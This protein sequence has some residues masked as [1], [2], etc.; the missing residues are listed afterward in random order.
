MSWD[1]DH[2]AV[3][4]CIRLIL[5]DEFGSRLSSLPKTNPPVPSVVINHTNGILPPTTYIS[6]TFIPTNDDDSWVIDSGLITVTVPDPDNPP[7]TVQM[8]TLYQ[9]VLVN[10]N[11][12]IRVASNPNS[13]NY[14]ND[15]C[16]GL[17]RDIRKLLLLDKI[18]N[19]LKDEVFTVVHLGN[20]RI[21]ST[22]DLLAKDYHEIAVMSL[23]CTSVDRS[24]N[25]DSGSFDHA[26]WIGELKLIDETDPNPRIIIGETQPVTIP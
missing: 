16:F 17:M 23:R 3:M 20:N 12:E 10:F 22:P 4:Q 18:R 14:V 2:R 5:I 11:I 19:K 1:F 15:N 26:S 24:I 9:D 8:D 25:Y 21:R 7:A 13:P 6:L